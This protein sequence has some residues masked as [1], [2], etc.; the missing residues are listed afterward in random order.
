RVAPRMRPVALLAVC[1]S[2]IATSVARS[3]LPAGAH[4]AQFATYRGKVA[5]AAAANAVFWAAWAT[6]VV[7]ATRFQDRREAAAAGGSVG[8]Q[9]PPPPPPPPARPASFAGVP[10][11]LTRSKT[12]AAHAAAMAS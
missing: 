8:L 5:I 2:V 7:A 3:S 9:P 6:V 10:V 4:A 11:A 1:G 12:G